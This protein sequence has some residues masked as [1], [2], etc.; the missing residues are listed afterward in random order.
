MSPAKKPKTPTVMNI[1]FLDVGQGDGTF[2]EIMPSRMMILIDFGERHSPYKIGIEDAITF[3]CDRIAANSKKRD[4][5]YPTI[6]HLF[7]THADSDHINYIQTLVNS[8]FFGFGKKTLRFREVTYS[9]LA[10]EYGD[11]IGELTGAKHSLP[12]NY[13]RQFLHDGLPPYRAYPPLPKKGPQPDQVKVF[14]LSANFPNAGY[15]NKNQKSLVLKIVLGNFSAIF[16]GDATI[17][18]ENNIIGWFSY[19]KK[20]PFLGASAMKIGHHASKHSSGLD[21]INSVRPKAIFA[22]GDFKWSHPYCETLCRYL[23]VLGPKPTVPPIMAG[24]LR[25]VC[26]ESGEYFNNVTPKMIFVNLW[27]VTPVENPSTEMVPEVSAKKG[28]PKPSVV[29]PSAVYGVQWTVEITGIGEPVISRTDTENPKFGSSTGR[30]WN[31]AT[32]GP[33]PSLFRTI[34]PAAVRRK[35]QITPLPFRTGG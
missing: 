12:D 19:Y 26:G 32:G 27:F 16:C 5:E 9:G 29:G 18:T 28:K 22:S 35:P 34:V 17:T 30:K 7:L 24:P 8:K 13:S 23:G 3:L 31:C 4:L 33:T 15:D 1:H 14:I 10:S 6:D 21:W 11:L 20:L 25:M 2:I